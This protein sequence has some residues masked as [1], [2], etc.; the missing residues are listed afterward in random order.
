MRTALTRTNP[1]E[2]LLQR[3]PDSEFDGESVEP[4][5]SRH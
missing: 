3:D 5:E 4:R 1:T 2:K